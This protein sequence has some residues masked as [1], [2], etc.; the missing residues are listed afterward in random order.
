MS[1]A[2]GLFALLL[3]ISACEAP[4]EAAPPARSAE[5]D[6]AA[7]RACIA[8]ELV[9]VSDEEIDV[10]E[11]SLPADIETSTQAQG[12][13]RAQLAALQFAQVLHD[14]AQL[15]HASLAH[16]D[17]ALNRAASSADSARHMATAARYAPRRPE[18]GT[19]EANVASEYERRFSR[20]RSDDDHRC[21]WD[22]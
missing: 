18:Q 13:W 4:R 9:R 8:A 10:I 21:N 19:L 17:S 6:E 1:R 7:R 5:R 12:I 14:H 2:P 22:L 11:A 16:A 3:L 15:R 20:I